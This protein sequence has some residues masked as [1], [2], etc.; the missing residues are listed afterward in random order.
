MILDSSVGVEIAIRSQIG[1]RAIENFTDD[2]FAPELFIAE[3][4]NVLK[5]LAL[6]KKITVRDANESA[7]VITRLPITY[8]PVVQ[9]QSE[10]WHLAQRISCYDSHYV[11]LA[12]ELK[13][14]ILTLDIRLT[15][16]SGLK[17]KFVQAV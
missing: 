12:Q 16:V 17:V 15:R 6:T 7:D 3:V 10:L 8:I 11:V 2:F 9:Y 4:H 5:K 13:L 1:K 14:P